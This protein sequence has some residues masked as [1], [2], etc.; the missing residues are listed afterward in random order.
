MKLLLTSAGLTNQSIIHALGDLLGKPFSEA[1][2]VF[3][4]TAANAEMGDKGWLIDDLQN[5]QKVGFKEIDIVDI[6]ALPKEMWQ[7]RLEKADILFFEG[8]NTFHLMHWIKKSGLSEFLPEM[9]KNKIYIGVSAGSMVATPSLQLSTSE[10][11]YG[12]ES[13]DMN[14]I[15]GLGLVQLQVRPHFNS[16]FFPNVTEEAVAELAKNTTDPVY[17][18]DDQTAIKIVDDQVEVISEGSWKRF[19]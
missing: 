15:E 12:N 10:R 17:V 19:N 11:L 8:G 5:C 6:S 3:I 16:A 1:T 4:P 13:E 7:P 9:L 14:S 18:I 2:L